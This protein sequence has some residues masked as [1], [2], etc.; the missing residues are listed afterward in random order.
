MLSIQTV[1]RL[2]STRNIEFESTNIMTNTLTEILVFSVLSGGVSCS[3]GCCRRFGKYLENV[4]YLKSLTTSSLKRCRWIQIIDMLNNR[5]ISPK[6]NCSTLAIP[7]CFYKIS[8]A[9]DGFSTSIIWQIYHPPELKHRPIFLLVKTILCLWNARWNHDRKCEARLKMQ[10]FGFVNRGSKLDLKEI[11]DG[12]PWRPS[13]FGRSRLPKARQYN[14]NVG[15]VH[16]NF[17]KFEI[18][19]G[20]LSFG[21][22]RPPP[23]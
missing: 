15:F 2:F 5:Q 17:S 12:L 20:T 9:F 11:W 18:F 14:L 6:R 16:R 23:V 13:L 22:G 7:W 1:G 10:M 21:R 8:R 3:K 4:D 19:H